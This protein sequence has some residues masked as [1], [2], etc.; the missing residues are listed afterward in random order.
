[1]ASLYKRANAQQRRILRIV[2]GA[3]KNAA[4]HH[5]EFTCFSPQLARSIAKRAAGT[6]SAE[7]K[8]SALAAVATKGTPSDVFRAGYPSIQ[9]EPLVPQG[10]MAPEPWRPDTCRPGT[11]DKRGGQQFGTGR[12]SL[13]SIIKALSR[14]T[15]EWKRGD[16]LMQ[17]QALG[18]IEAL[19]IIDGLKKGD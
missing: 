13:A 1:M 16:A 12:P 2:E 7:G 10:F 15:A 11:G 8:R 3:V 17:L 6:L 5:P 14:K 9:A 4:D 19:R 18:L